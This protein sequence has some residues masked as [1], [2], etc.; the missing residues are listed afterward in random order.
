MADSIHVRELATACGR[1]FGVATLAAPETLNALTLAMVDVLQ[2][3]LTRWATDP[4]VIGVV[5]D[6][7]GEKAFC[8]GGDVM[9]LYRSMVDGDAMP[10]SPNTYARQFFSREYRLDYLIHVY[11]KPLLCWGNGIVMG[12]GLGLFAGASHRVV[13]ER[14]RMAM[15][16]IGIGLFPDVGGSWFL[17]RMPGRLGRFLA[18]TGAQLDAADARFVGLADHRLPQAARDAVDT[19]IAE[20]RWQAEPAADSRRLSHLLEAV[21]R[22]TDEGGDA[23]ARS[24]EGPTAASRLRGHYD[25]V[26]L[27]V[28]HDSLADSAVRMAAVA[29]DGSWLGTAAR[30]FRRG[31]PTSARLIDELLRRARH[32]SLREVF[33]LELDV[34]LGCC[35]H[36]DFREGVRALL[37]DRDRK[38][39]WQ[40][41]RLEDVDDALVADHFRH[42]YPGENPLENL[43]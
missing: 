32:L 4:E 18:L 14:T 34:A 12:G 21:A 11:P 42:R 36:H 2:T 5:L 26:D 43:R 41:A 37:V 8:A 1:R 6:G 31:S 38:P 15:P 25:E 39:R 29:D 30:N 22:S 33:Q 40:P 20:T 23:G 13:T 24:A 17:N 10:D 9:E 3:Q 27:L 7:E 28:G 35:A 16:E 19:A